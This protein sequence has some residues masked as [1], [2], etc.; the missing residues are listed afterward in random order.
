[1]ERKCLLC[2]RKCVLYKICLCVEFAS[3]P[4]LLSLYALYGGGWP[5]APYLGGMYGSGSRRSLTDCGHTGLL[6]H[7]IV[8]PSVLVLEPLEIKCICVSLFNVILFAYV[9]MQSMQ[10]Q[11]KV[12]ILRNNNFFWNLENR[13][14][15]YICFGESLFFWWCICT[16]NSLSRY[17]AEVFLFRFFLDG[18]YHSIM[19]LYVSKLNKIIHFPDFDKKIPTK[20]CDGK[21]T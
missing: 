8:F 6:G 9:L 16:S 3:F 19:I 13:F 18:S 21:Y 7:T 4:R 12:N 17:F 1:M 11:K 20:V 15:W 2:Y 10:W 14:F 5:Y